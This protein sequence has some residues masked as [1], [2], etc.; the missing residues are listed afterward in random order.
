M[1]ERGHLSW[2]HNPHAAQS[3][4]GSIVVAV[5]LL[6]LPTAGLAAP[7]PGA[8]SQ[9][10]GRYVFVTQDAMGLGFRDAKVTLS[11]LLLNAAGQQSRRKLATQYLEV[12]DDGNKTMI[13]FQYPRDIKGTSLLTFEH[14]ETAD[15]QWLYLP[16]LKR[17]KRI[18]SKNKSGSFMGSEFSY[19]DISSNKP[20]KYTY[21]YL[22]EDTHN[23]VPVWVV[24][25]YPKDPTSGYTK[26]IAWVD[27]S[28]YQNVKQEYFDRKGAPL[29][30]EHVTSHTRHLGKFWRPNEIIMENLQTKKK[31][32]LAFENWLFQQGLRASRFTKRSLERQR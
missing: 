28:N 27:H 21:K 7:P 6:I 18:A 22:R 9:E 5:L 10:Q 32:I 12:A 19:E 15:D 31:T 14:I 2:E 4:W 11:M 26:I 16:A 30:V 20:Q 17:V 8:S 25:R 1:N 23:S 29:K 24:E 13:T 3:R